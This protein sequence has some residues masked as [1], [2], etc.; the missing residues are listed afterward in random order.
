[1]TDATPIKVEATVTEKPPPP[2]SP[3]GNPDPALPQ[4]AKETSG[5]FDD[6]MRFFVSAWAMFGLTAFLAIVAFEKMLT[7]EMILTVI[8]YFAGWISGSNNFYVGSSSGSKIKD[9]PPK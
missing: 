4:N 9:M 1:V 3:P 8:A 2:T 6:W 5:R 7:P